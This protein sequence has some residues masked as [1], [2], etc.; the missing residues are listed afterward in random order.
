MPRGY[1]GQLRGRPPA[2]KNE[3]DENIEYAEQLAD[4]IVGLK[5]SKP[6]IHRTYWSRRWDREFHK[7]MDQICWE[8]GI[9][10]QSYQPPFWLHRQAS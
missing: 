1:T 4:S 6:G 9:R 7:A 3:I 8:K 2:P 10:R 5:P